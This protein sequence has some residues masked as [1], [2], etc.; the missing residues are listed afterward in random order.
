MIRDIDHIEEG[1]ASIRFVIGEYGA[2][3]TFFL[4]LV[5]LIALRKGMVVMSADLT[6]SRRLHATGGQARS[7]F[8]E[9]T[10]TCQPEQ[11]RGRRPCQRR[12][13]LCDACREGR[14]PQWPRRGRGNP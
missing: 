3:K 11:T 14:K 6:P 2:G 8:A 5:R 1:G 7:L 4:I 13:A 10:V 12:R 9:M